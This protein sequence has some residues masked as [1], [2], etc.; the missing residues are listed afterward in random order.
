MWQ[1]PFPDGNTGEDGYLLTSPVGT[2]GETD[3][4]ITDLAGNVWEW[5]EDWFRPYADR[6]RPFR[7]TPGAEKV[8]RGGSFLC[9]P[10]WCHGYRVTARSHAEPGSAFFHTGFRLVRDIDR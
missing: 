3:L 7:P 6:D 8:M 4:G 2:F 9:H 5:T 1:G 10:S